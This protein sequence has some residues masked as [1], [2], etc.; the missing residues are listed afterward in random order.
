[1]RHGESAETLAR[2]FTEDPMES[3]SAQDSSSIHNAFERRLDISRGLGTLSTMAWRA[4]R[5]PLAT[6]FVAASHPSQQ[7]GCETSES[8][9]H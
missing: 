8:A 6:A 2:D 4:S 3:G 1:M 9:L 5:R 7:N